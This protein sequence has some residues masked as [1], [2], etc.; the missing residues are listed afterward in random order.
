MNLLDLSNWRRFKRCRQ[1]F[2]SP[3]RAHLLTASGS[4]EPVSLGLS[5]GDTLHIPK[6]RNARRLLRW[7]LDEVENPWPITADE[8]L[9]FFT[10]GH[11]T[12]A[13]R[14]IDTDFYTFQEVILR[15]GY[16]ISQL[17][18]PLG[19]VVDIGTNIGLFSLCVAPLAERLIC[20]EP[21]DE[22]LQIARR[23]IELANMSDKA[24]FHNCAIADKP[25]SLRLF[26]SDHNHGGHSVSAN[27]TAQWGSTKEVAVP[28]ITLE[29]LFDREN[30]ERCSL[31]KCD[32]EGAEFEI[33]AAAPVELLA[34][35]DRI[36]MEVHLTGSDWNEEVFQNLADKL[37]EA[38]HKVQ[39]EP[40]HDAKGNLRKTIL[41]ST[42]RS[43]DTLRCSYRRK[44]LTFSKKSALR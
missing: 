20:V 37:R 10:H 36:L 40:L 21:V 26:L 32:V 28:A 22:N 17:T 16:G 43:S 12:I 25:G 30:I 2:S 8:N 19:T 33:F 1:V 4:P 18:E 44:N 15:D 14:P 27:H 38:G 23:N 31:L 13:I 6:I 5:S 3:L 39:H 34:R 29:Q 42:S 35:V 24:A 9:I 7:L 41:L 11:R